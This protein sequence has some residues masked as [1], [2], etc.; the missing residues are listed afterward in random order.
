VKAELQSNE[1]LEG[2]I[3]LEYTSLK[4]EATLEGLLVRIPSRNHAMIL[5]DYTDQTSTVSANASRDALVIGTAWAQALESDLEP[6]RLDFEPSVSQGKFSPQT[7]RMLEAAHGRVASIGTIVNVEKIE[8]KRDD[9]DSPVTDQSARG[10]AEDIL[11]DSDVRTYLTRGD[12]IV[13]ISFQFDWQYG[14]ASKPRHFYSRVT[15]S[16]VDGALY[17]R[18]SR[19]GQSI[20]RASALFMEIRRALAAPTKP[21]RA[22]ELKTLLKQIAL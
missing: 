15:I 14:S 10:A 11:L 2:V 12:H 19:G 18:V 21:A 13:S 9:P 22:K 5:L 3:Y 20:D 8:T 17:V 6:A 1:M 4:L 7:V 16:S